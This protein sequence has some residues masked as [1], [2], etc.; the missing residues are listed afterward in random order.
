MELIAVYGLSIL[1]FAAA[2]FITALYTEARKWGR[3][4]Q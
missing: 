3:R 1:L 4:H 2:L